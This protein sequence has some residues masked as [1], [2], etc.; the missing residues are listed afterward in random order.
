MLCGEAGRISLSIS[1]CEKQRQIGSGEAKNIF[2]GELQVN[3]VR[4]RTKDE[5]IT[6]VPSL[7]SG[8]RPTHSIPWFLALVLCAYPSVTRRPK[9]ENLKR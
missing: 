6:R 2:A 8:R 7:L 3:F 1:Q 9:Y 5:T 4:I